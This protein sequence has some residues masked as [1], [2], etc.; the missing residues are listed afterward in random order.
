MRL[1]A[2]AIMQPLNAGFPIEKATALFED[3]IDYSRSIEE[4]M[5]EIH[6]LF[7]IS[8][9]FKKGQA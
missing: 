1:T 6:G 4:L 2:G 5:Q 7:K 8:D 9:F 3:Y